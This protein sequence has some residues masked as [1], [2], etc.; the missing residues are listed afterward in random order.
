[1]VREKFQWIMNGNFSFNKNEIT[2]LYG[3]KDPVTGK[4]IDDISNR[5]FI[6]QPVRVNYDYVWDGIWQLGEE[7]AAAV[8]GFT[9]RICQIKRP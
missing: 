3:I 7:E 2:S 9:A 4:E 6:G 5:W 8:Y 1:M